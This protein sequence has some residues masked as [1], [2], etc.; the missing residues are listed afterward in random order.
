MHFCRQLL[1]NTNISYMYEKRKICAI[2]GIYCQ[3]I[4][5]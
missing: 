2:S 4:K 1:G 3:G 5:V